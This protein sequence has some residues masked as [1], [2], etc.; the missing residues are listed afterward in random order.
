MLLSLPQ[1]YLLSLLKSFGALRDDQAAKLLHM[2]NEFAKLEPTVYPLVCRGDVIR[3]NG[4]IIARGGTFS[5]DTIAAI[6]VMLLLESKNIDTIQTGVKPFD[7]T[8]FKLK[9]DKLCR[10]DICVVMPGREAVIVAALEGIFTKHRT[11]VFVLKE[12]SQ[13]ELLY[14]PCDYCFAIK[15]ND[16]YH[17]FKAE[18]RNN[19]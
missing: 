13:R 12:L 11:I 5:H 10:Y 3:D 18:R 19:L 2:N 16:K 7:L 14:A 15:E 6:D 1:K 8:F 9:K 4:Y 17:F